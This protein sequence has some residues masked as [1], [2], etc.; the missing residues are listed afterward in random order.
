MSGIMKVFLLLAVMVYISKAQL[1][2]DHT[3]GNEC[4]CRRLRNGISSKRDIKDIQINPATVFCDKVQ[5]VVTLNSGHR[6]CLN[7]RLKAVQK[8]MAKVMK[9]VTSTTARPTELTATPY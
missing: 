3:S 5:I 7:P 6:Y 8:L 9:P 4:M 2:G 1:D